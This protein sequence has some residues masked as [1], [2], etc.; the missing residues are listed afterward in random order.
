MFLKCVPINKC[1]CVTCKFVFPKMHYY[2]I[3]YLKYNAFDGI[4]FK[5]PSHHTMQVKL[6]MT[7]YSKCV[8]IKCK[9]VFPKPYSC[10]ITQLSLLKTMLLMVLG[11]SYLQSNACKI[12]FVWPGNL[13]EQL[14]FRISK[15]LMRAASSLTKRSILLS[16]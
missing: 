2:T 5:L 13:T 14:L 3:N 9:F 12:S 8:C 10:I 15:T 11:L 1:T 4:G 16:N 6:C 7:G